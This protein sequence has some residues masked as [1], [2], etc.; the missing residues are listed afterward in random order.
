MKI[1]LDPRALKQSIVKDKYQMPNIDNLIGM[2][3]EK[4]HEKKGV[5]VFVGRHDLCVR[6][7][8]LTRINYK[9]LQFSNC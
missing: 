1:A 5:V 9:T 7:N 2:I 6:T 3:A 8:S 4:L